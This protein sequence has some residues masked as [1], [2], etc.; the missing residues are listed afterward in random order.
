MPGDDPFDDIFDE[1][2]R[3]LDDLFGGSGG[4][5]RPI[6][7]ARGAR[8]DVAEREAE[9]EVVADLPGVDAGE[10]E[11]EC[12]GETLRILAGNYD[13]RVSLP[14]PVDETSADAQFNNGVL[15]VAFEPAGHDGARLD[16]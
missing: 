10:V 3:L 15:S 9:V 5:D 12:D 13:N 16:G 8:V 11:M 14:V 2:E 6:V 1:F 4:D 7:D